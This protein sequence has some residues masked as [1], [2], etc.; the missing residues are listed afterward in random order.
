MDNQ[1]NIGRCIRI[2]QVK[3]EMTGSDLAAIMNVSRQQVARWRKADD[4]KWSRV[5]LFASAFQMPVLE[6]LSLDYD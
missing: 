3:K 6:F 2:A 5:C 4:M 1:I